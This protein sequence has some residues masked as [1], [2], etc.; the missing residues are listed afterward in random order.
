MEAPEVT[1]R[2]RQYS[3]LARHPARHLRATTLLERTSD[4]TPTMAPVSMEIR[5]HVGVIQL[6][7]PPVNALAIPGTPET[8]LMVK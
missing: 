3:T 2:L 1:S 4:A 8:P 7:N 5:D 6:S